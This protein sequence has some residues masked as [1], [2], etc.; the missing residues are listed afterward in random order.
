MIA[1]LNAALPLSSQATSELVKFNCNQLED[2]SMQ[3]IEEVLLVVGKE[4]TKTWFTDVVRYY[5]N[6]P[7]LYL[8]FPVH[9]PNLRHRPCPHLSFTTTVSLTGLQSLTELSINPRKLIFPGQNWATVS[10]SQ[11]FLHLSYADVQ[12]DVWA[13]RKIK[14][15]K[16]DTMFVLS[17]ATLHYITSHYITMHYKFYGS[18]KNPNIL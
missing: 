8:S 17:L 3:W 15:C 7:G 18:L 2:E 4:H 10:E 5:F 16:G 11:F 9:T 1:Q 13:H 14:Q 12:T 6:L